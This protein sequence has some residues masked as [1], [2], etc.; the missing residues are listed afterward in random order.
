MPAMA[1]AVHSQGLG[2]AAL[3]SWLLTASLGAWM[4]RSLIARDGLRRQRAVRNGLHPA[5]LVGHFCLALAGLAS[6]VSYLAT[7]WLQLAWLGVGLLTPAIGLG[8]ST[9][10]LW[11]PFPD[12]PIV[13]GTGTAAP[14]HSG[15]LTPP[16]EDA[17]TRKLTDEV[18]ASAVT[19]EALMSRLVEEVVAS[20]RADPV[21]SGRRPRAHLAALI[22][23]GHGM[24]AMA[25]F[26]LAVVAATIGS[27]R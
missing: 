7:G 20:V 17:L 5:V 14:H 21:Q 26:V 25:T 15:M 1:A 10:T 22:P 12:E 16:P 9:L 3:A 8:I 18:L 11:T 4:L 2:I 19:D 6:W 27:S 13:P 24:G 23:V